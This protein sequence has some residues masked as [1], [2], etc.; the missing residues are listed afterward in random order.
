MPSLAEKIAT[1][2]LATRKPL[3]T[4][5]IGNEPGGRAWLI[6]VLG[7]ADEAGPLQELAIDLRRQSNLFHLI[8]GQHEHPDAEA[9]HSVAWK[10]F[11]RPTIWAVRAWRANPPA[12][13]RAAAA[14]DAAAEYYRASIA[15][16]YAK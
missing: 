10:R 4:K 12:L 11:E 3:L 14:L 13:E 1:A 15:S 7:L 5:C 9:L 16:M 8:C 6:E 2:V